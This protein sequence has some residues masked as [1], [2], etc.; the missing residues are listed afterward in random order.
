MNDIYFGIIFTCIT[1]S[2]FS[3]TIAFLMNL[4]IYYSA[5]DDKYPLFPILN[6][7]S[8]SSYELMFKSMFKMKWN[9]EG[10]N[11]KFKKKSNNLRNFSGIIIL[12]A[13]VV[14]ILNA[15]IN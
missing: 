7:L 9:I 12:L 10:E 5:E 6:P 13:I 15:L 11:K 8:A 2:I 14:G 4:W 1:L 3:F